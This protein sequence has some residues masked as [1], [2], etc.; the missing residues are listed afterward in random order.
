[1]PPFLT[2]SLLSEIRNIKNPDFKERAETLIDNFRGKLAETAKKS[3]VVM[4]AQTAFEEIKQ[5]SPQTPW[6]NEAE[7]ERDI[8]RARNVIG[9]LWLAR[10]RELEG[11]EGNTIE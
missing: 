6:A 1:M 4:T 2:P 3:D 10:A 9:Y 7:K 11:T 5:I 8:G